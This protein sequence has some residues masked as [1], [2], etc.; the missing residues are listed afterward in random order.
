M[1]AVR[2]F[3]NAREY[4]TP[5]LQESAFLEKG[6]LTPEEVRP[7]SLTLTYTHFVTK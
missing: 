6:M 7:H 1:Q 4:L 2:F 5:V 3:K